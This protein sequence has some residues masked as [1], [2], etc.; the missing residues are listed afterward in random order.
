[1]AGPQELIKPVIVQTLIHHQ[2][3]EERSI[4]NFMGETIADVANRD[5]RRLVLRI[6]FSSSDKKKVNP[7]T[8]TLYNVQRDRLD[9]Q[10]IKQACGGLNGYLWGSWKA[11]AVMNDETEI[12]LWAASE[13][14]A[15]DRVTALARFVEGDLDVINSY[16]EP[17]EGKRVLYDSLYKQP[18]RQYPY[19]MLI[20]NPV[21]I[22]NE[23]NGKATRKGVY[24]D[25]QAIIPLWTETRPDDWSEKLQALF[26]TPGPNDI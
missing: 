18:R 11:I 26:A 21:Q 14:E 8:V 2:L 24:K 15:I 23:E 10:D 9:W 19:E 6:V 12:R 20:I 3:L 22:L 25:R 5:I 17:R 16:H 4:G 7:T 1:L 13:A